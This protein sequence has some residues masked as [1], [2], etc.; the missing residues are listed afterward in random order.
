MHNSMMLAGLPAFCSAPL[1]FF[2]TDSMPRLTWKGCS[3]A[4]KVM[5]RWVL[6]GWTCWSCLW[7]K[8]LVLRVT[9]IVL[10]EVHERSSCQSWHRETWQVTDRGRFARLDASAPRSLHTDF[11]L[12]ILRELLYRRSDLKLVLMLGAY[13]PILKNDFWRFS[14]LKPLAK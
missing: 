1:A 10:D 12:T 13:R 4:E 8:A 6:D 14:N 3:V 9:H 5:C 7:Q 11:L 2:W